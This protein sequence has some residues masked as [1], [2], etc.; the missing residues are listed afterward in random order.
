MTSPQSLIGGKF[1]TVFFQFKKKQFYSL[2]QLSSLNDNIYYWYLISEFFAKNMYVAIK[3]AGIVISVHY[4]T[5]DTL[6]N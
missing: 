3:K 2:F 1:A 5:M 6:L 4:M